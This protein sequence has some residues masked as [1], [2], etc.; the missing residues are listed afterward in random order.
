MRS[1]LPGVLLLAAC[2][3]NDYGVAKDADPNPGAG[4]PVDLALDVAFQSQNHGDSVTRCQVQVA[5]E[6]LL[7]EGP[8]TARTLIGGDLAR[9]EAPGTCAFT[10][11][12]VTRGTPAEEDADNWQVQGGV[13]GPEQIRM[14]DDAGALSLWALRTDEG[15]LRYELPDC[16]AGVFPFSR[17]LGLDV[18]DSDDPDGVHAFT[19]PDLVAVGPQVSLD[20]PER[21]EEGRQPTL[22]PREPMA[23]RWTLLGPDPEIEGA[24]AASTTLIQ[25]QHQHETRVEADRWLVCWPE[26]EGWF[27]VPP[28]D[29]ALLV[30]GRDDPAEWRAHVDVHTEVVG[31][32]QLT[33]WGRTLQV[34]AHVSAGGGIELATLE[35]ATR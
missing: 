3:G 35:G 29:L 30:D 20:A 16:D 19:V 6:P 4:R 1:I 2:R 10:E 25:I 32:P 27:D 26:D 5:F 8:D 12:P 24:P 31:A 21:T 7:E 13:I 11:L 9:P 15:D 28:E 17:T 23:V 14:Q 18:P 34:R 22:D 33:P